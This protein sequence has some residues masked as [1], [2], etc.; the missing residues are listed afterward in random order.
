MI[1]KESVIELALHNTTNKANKTTC[2]VY[3]RVLLEVDLSL[4]F[5]ALCG[6]RVVALNEWVVAPEIGWFA[7]GKVAIR[8]HQYSG[9]N[10]FLRSK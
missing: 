3:W 10:V 5:G 2:C 9:K 6:R 1:K 8:P 7:D 4:G